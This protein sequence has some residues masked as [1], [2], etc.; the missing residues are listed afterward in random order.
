MAWRSHARQSFMPRP[1]AEALTWYSDAN[2]PTYLLA[3]IRSV[4]KSGCADKLLADSS[5]YE[6][7]VTDAPLSRPTEAVVVRWRGVIQPEPGSVLIE[8]ES[9]TGQNDTL[10]RPESEAVPLFWRFVIEKLG[11]DPE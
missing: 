6:L 10:T 5:A 7:A 1:W 2:A 8:H 9:H 4:L 11:V 3:I